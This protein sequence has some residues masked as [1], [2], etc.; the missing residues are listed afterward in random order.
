MKITKTTQVSLTFAMIL[1]MLCWGGTWPFAKLIQG[2]LPINS[3]IFYR[4]FF[5][6]LG[7]ILIIWA[8]KKSF[9]LPKS[10]LKY[11]FFGG[12]L[13][14]AYHWLFFKGLQSGGLPGASGVLTTSL[15]PLATFGFSAMVYRKS[16]HLKEWIGL[17]LGVSSAIIFLQ[18]WA[19]HPDLF[20]HGTLYFLAAPIVWA[21]LSLISQKVTTTSLVYT[22]YLLAGGG[23]V[24]FFLT[25]WPDLIHIQNQSSQFW[26]SMGFLVIAGNLLGTSIFFQTVEKLGPKK[27]ASFMF[28]IPSAAVVF[29]YLMFKEIPTFT[30]LIAGSLALLGV[31]VLNKTPKTEINGGRDKA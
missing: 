19:P 20:S 3:I 17:G 9:K 15:I 21:V 14:A 8:Q 23:I 6:V 12:G 31:Y 4:F 28:I 11:V 7:F 16:L 13:M 24:F 5:S 1:A 27:A 30:T 26:I 25:P 2:S 29:S 18:L 10:D 22:C